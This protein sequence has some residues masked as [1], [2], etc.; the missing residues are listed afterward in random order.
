MATMAI[1]VATDGNNGNNGNN[2]NGGNNGN[3]G[4]NLDADPGPVDT[5]HTPEGWIVWINYQDQDNDGQGDRPEGTGQDFNENTGFKVTI[6]EIDENGDENDITDNVKGVAQTSGG[7]DGD[8]LQFNV[9]TGSSRIT[10]Q[11]TGLVPDHVAIFVL[12]ENGVVVD[13]T[14]TETFQTQPL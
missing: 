1:T 14:G 3:N 4:N 6:I 12:D 9:P 5:H 13:D 7:Q 2:G 11:V 10:I 8:A